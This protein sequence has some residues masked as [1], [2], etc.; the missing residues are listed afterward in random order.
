MDAHSRD[1]N[2]LPSATA[3]GSSMLQATCFLCIGSNKGTKPT[4]NKKL[5]A[6]CNI[7]K[8]TIT[9]EKG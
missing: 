1:R 7:G 2:M 9:K 4:A 5:Y 6:K 8:G 3:L